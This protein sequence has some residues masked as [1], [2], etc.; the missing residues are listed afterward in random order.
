ME[1]WFT[2]SLWTFNTEDNLQKIS[3]GIFGVPK[4]AL[5]G[6]FAEELNHVFESLES[7]T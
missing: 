5:E 4:N 2:L 3:I 1:Y 7:S 6:V